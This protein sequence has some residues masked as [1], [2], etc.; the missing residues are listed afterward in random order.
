MD[1]FKRKYT[2]YNLIEIY[3]S[4]FLANLDYYSF[5]TMKP[6]I[7]VLKSNAYGV[8]IRH[9]S[10]ILQTVQ[11]VEMIAVDGYFEALEV[12]KYFS[13]EIL[14]M[15]AIMK[16]NYKFLKN[17]F[18]YA[19]GDENILDEIII[20]SN[21]GKKFKIQLEFDTGMKRH[22]FNTDDLD[23]I[24]II[25]TKIKNAK[26]IEVTGIFSHYYDV[27]SAS[28]IAKQSEKLKK[29][30]EYLKKEFS[31]LSYIHL[32]ASG[33]AFYENNF[34]NYVRV[35]AGLYG[36][37]P[38]EKGSKNYE[39]FVENVNPVI[40]LSSRVNRVF[41]IK[42]GETVGYGGNYVAEKNT[43]IA[44][45]PFGYYEGIPR[46]LSNKLKVKIK[47][48]FY[49]VAGNICMNITMLEVDDSVRV[50]D[51]IIIYSSNHEDENSIL[52]ISENFGISGYE[53]ITRL[54]EKIR[55]VVY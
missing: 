3:S 36:I 26:N 12:C 33:G 13:K 35:G 49:K 6:L 52:N 41:E 17:N 9:I 1:L 37:C 38:F 50:G 25:T 27:N 20:L 30:L 53:M 44:T 23:Y 22:G 31:S 39:N 32:S 42:K 5:L 47:G 54:S 8:G 40:E 7:P 15:G 46:E 45:M 4:V 10:K 21:K 28:R 19:I 29:I 11:N 55:R 14:V 24:K 34:E 51:K 18:H 43:Y 16:E 48:K 2:T